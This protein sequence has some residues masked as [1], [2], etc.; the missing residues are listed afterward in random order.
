M[1][2]EFANVFTNNSACNYTPLQNVKKWSTCPGDCDC[3]S[4]WSNFI[5]S[6]TYGCFVPQLVILHQAV[7]VITSL[8]SQVRGKLGIRSWYC[9]RTDS[10]CFYFTFFRLFLL[11]FLILERSKMLG[12][13][14]VRMSFYLTLSQLIMESNLALWIQ[15][16]EAAGNCYLYRLAISPSKTFISGFS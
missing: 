4:L 11:C 13:W 12:L 3:V 15:A 16:I 10:D 8:E 5:Y 1:Q 2:C 14:I 7:S 9:F 6:P